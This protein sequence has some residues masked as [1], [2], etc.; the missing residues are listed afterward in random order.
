M[1]TRLEVYVHIVTAA[2][3][4]TQN[5]ITAV[6]KAGVHVDDTVFEPLACADAVLSLRNGNSVFVW[7]ISARAHRTWLFF[8]RAPSR[9]RR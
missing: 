7:P 2:S 4:A 9:I 3:S 1:A 8:R 5:V 6:N